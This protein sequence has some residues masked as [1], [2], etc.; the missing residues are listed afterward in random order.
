MFNR[1]QASKHG[2]SVNL[3]IEFGYAF[4]YTNFTINIFYINLLNTSDEIENKEHEVRIYR[5]WSFDPTNHIPN[6]SSYF[7]KMIQII[8]YNNPLFTKVSKVSRNNESY[9]KNN[10]HDI[11]SYV[12]HSE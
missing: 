3:N 4:R 10:F 11:A 6:E 8:N 7:I 2:Q 9:P 5:F 12:L 1:D